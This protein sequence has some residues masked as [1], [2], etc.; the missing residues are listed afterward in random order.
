MPIIHFVIF[1]GGF[2]FI[3]AGVFYIFFSAWSFFI[4]LAI[5]G[6]NL[7]SRNSRQVKKLCLY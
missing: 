3:I 5:P 7:I 1:A 4:G 2:L 6:I